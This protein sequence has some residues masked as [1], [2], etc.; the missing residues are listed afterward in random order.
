LFTL[1]YHVALGERETILYD[2]LA[3]E[4]RQTSFIASPGAS[5]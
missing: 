5:A 1:G 4:A 3:S 2:L